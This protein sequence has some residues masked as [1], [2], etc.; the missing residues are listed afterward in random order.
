MEKLVRMP[1]AAKIA[2]CLR[3]SGTRPM[4][5]AMASAGDAGAI[6]LPSSVMVPAAMRSAPKMARASSVRPEPTRPATPRISP[7]LRSRSTPSS[8]MACGACGIAHG[9]QAAHREPDVAG[10]V[11]LRRPGIELGGGAADHLLDDLRQLDRP[12]LAVEMPGQPAV[13]QHRHAVADGGGLFQPVGDEHDGDAVLAQP[14][15][16]RHQPLHLG[17]GQRRGRL[18]HDDEAALQRQRAGDLDQLLLGD[19]QRRHRR[20]R[21]D[22]EA[23]AGDDRRATSSS[24][25]PPADQPER[26]ERRAADK[27]VLRHRQRRDQA[28]FLVDGDDAEPLGVL[29]TGRTD[30]RR[31]RRRCGR[32][33]AA[34]RRT[35]S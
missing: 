26:P 29:R 7:A 34:S 31:R 13:A 27:D 21:I 4:P 2:W 10:D 8:T 19:R 30:I 15:H 23:D 9:A 25:L 12:A 5:S 6:G 28:Q 17:L 11:A 14:V 20:R 33:R 18:V 35:G 16:D 24:I 32:S 22:V 3:S 1:S